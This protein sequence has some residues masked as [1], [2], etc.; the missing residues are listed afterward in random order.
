MYRGIRITIDRKAQRKLKNTLDALNLRSAEVW[1]ETLRLAKEHYASTGKWANQSY[2]QKETKG[3]VELH[4]QS[5]QAVVHKYLSARDGILADRKRGNKKARFPHR[6]RR[7]YNTKWVDKAFRVEGD[8]FLF[9]MGNHGGKR[10]PALKVKTTG[11]PIDPMHM[12][13]VELCFDTEYYLSVTY[14]DG[15]APEPYAS[16][17]SVGVD[18]GEIHS[19]AAF[20]EH[21]E[22]VLIS[23]RK[24]RSIHRLRNKRLGELQRLQSKCKKGSKRWKRLQQAK[25]FVRTKSDRQLKDALHKTTRQFVDWCIEQQVSDIYVGDVEGVQR[26]TKKKRHKKTN[27]KLSNWAFGKLM[28]Y[29]AYK[30]EHHGMKTHKVDESYS[31]QT[32][33]VC[34]VRKK[35]NGRT[36][37]CTCGYESHRDLHGAKNILSKQLYGT[38]TTFPHEERPGVYRVA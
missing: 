25:R 20:A 18:L 11:I 6:N 27:Q 15:S 33:P 1:N 9:S 38:M 37:T 35:S 12:K 13:E 29:I 7:F 34:G 5:I 4:S 8:T 23:G 36:V 16:D 21:G 3:L 19:I 10:I 30:A 28:A 14:D 2:L 22:S 31:T 24:V 26:N 32:C 17:R